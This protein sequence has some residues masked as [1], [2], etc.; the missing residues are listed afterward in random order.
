[1]IFLLLLLLV[2]STYLAHVLSQSHFDSEGSS[3]R[4]RC[5]VT[6]LMY[7]VGPLFFVSSINKVY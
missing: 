4:L 3:F 2:F 6:F 7:V 1:M 5:A